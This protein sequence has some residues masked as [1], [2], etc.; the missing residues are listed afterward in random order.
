MGAAPP[1]HVGRAGGAGVCQPR[2]MTTAHTSEAPTAR[3]GDGWRQS[4]RDTAPPRSIVDNA[5]ARPRFLE[6]ERFR[7]DPAADAAQGVLPSRRRAMEALPPGGTVL[8][9]GVGG[10]KASL[11]L[12]AQAGLII[13]VD[14]SEDMLAS[15]E[16]SAAAIGVASRCVV[17]ASPEVG[18]EVDP[19]D[20]VVSN[21]ALYGAEEIEAFLDALTTHARHRVVLDVSPQPPPLGIAP[22]WKAIHGAERP[23]RPIADL[24]QGVLV[25]M[26]VEVE[27]EEAVIPARVRG[28]DTSPEWWRSCAGASWSARTVTPRSP[29]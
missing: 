12:A 26:G 3:P 15:F 25:A 7:W 2:A 8:D 6:P 9:V 29:S 27:R 4:L 22:L 21:N 10:G 24:L 20:V 13:G 23:S 18:A 14:M 17:G 19:V 1:D 5:P 16:A 11:G 28:R